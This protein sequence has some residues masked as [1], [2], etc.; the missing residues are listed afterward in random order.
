MPWKGFPP[1]GAGESTSFRPGI[2][3][4]QKNP[5]GKN[6]EQVRESEKSAVDKVRE[7]GRY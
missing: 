5:K 7:D 1:S 4:F 6:Q 2:R 3:I